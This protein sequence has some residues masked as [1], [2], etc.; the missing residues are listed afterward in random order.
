VAST[1]PWIEMNSTA[2]HRHISHSHTLDAVSISHMSHQEAIQL[3][4]YHVATHVTMWACCWCMILRMTTHPQNDDASTLQLQST[5]APDN[6]RKHMLPFGF[7]QS[8]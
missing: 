4:L 2:E 5:Q 8:C 7:V 6:K 1:V 3:R